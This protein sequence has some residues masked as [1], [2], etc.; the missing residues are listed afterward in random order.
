LWAIAALVVI[1]GCLP[2]L[3]MNRIAAALSSAFH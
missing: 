3:L 2:D 1:L